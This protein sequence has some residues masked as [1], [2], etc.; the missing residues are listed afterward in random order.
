MLDL[1]LIGIGTGNP[2]HV[3]LEAQAALRDAALVMVPHK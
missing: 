3:T 1:W 2:A